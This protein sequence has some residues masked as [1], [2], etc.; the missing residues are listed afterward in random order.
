M[1][2]FKKSGLLL[3]VALL[4]MSL[5]LSGCGGGG[6]DEPAETDANGEAEAPAGEQI[7]LRLSTVVNPPHPWIEMAEFFAE[8]VE[9]RTDGN[10]TISVY[11]SAQLGNDET[12]IDEMRTG[13][14]DFVIGGAQ[15]AASF[16][17]EYQVFGLAYLFEDYDHFEAAVAHGSPVFN[18][19]EE[20]YEEKG[21]GIQLLGL[22]GGGVRNVSNSERPIEQPED[23]QG[24]QMRL[25][26][27]PME[28][29]LWEAFGAIPTSLPWSEI[30]TAIQTG[31]VTTFESTISGYN[32][33]NLYEV[34]PYH[35]ETQHLFM[36]THFSMGDMTAEKLPAE[37]LDIVREVAIEASLFGT[38]M[39][40]QFDEEL[41]VELV[42]EKG[43]QLNEVDVD[44]F[45]EIAQP[46]HDELAA[47]INASDLLEMIRDLQ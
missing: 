6:A 3:L 42:E 45:I 33:S 16:V 7:N 13:T 2:F 44:A 40:K 10:V 29:V 4:V 19:F 12:T 5:A 18:R 41:L 24:M 1:K 37:Y 36:L 30:Y 31:V 20:L 25:P 39:G 8:E 34:A 23:L 28:A 47:D 46:L 22:A 35:S 26:G 17:P 11:P 21:L 14:I 38:E 9:A 27:S 43:V 32:G 15:N